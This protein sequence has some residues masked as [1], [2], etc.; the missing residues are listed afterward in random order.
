MSVVHRELNRLEVLRGL[1]VATWEAAFANI[2]VTLTTGAFLT[3]FA[4]WLGAGDVEVSLLSA[5]PTFAGLVQFVSSYFG[6]RLPARKP[7]CAWFLMAGRGLWVL[8]LLLPYLLGPSRSLYPFLVLYLL[9]YVAIN[10]PMPAYMAWMSDLVPA[11]HRGRYFGR[12]NMIAGGAGMLVGLPAAWFLDWTTR[13]THQEAL[14]FA[15]LFGVAVAG[16]VAALVCMLRQPEPPGRNTG[17]SGDR[18]QGTEGV[19]AYYR[20]PFADRNFR[21]LIMFNVVLG[22]GQFLAAPFFTVYALQSLQLNY[23][24][25]QLLSVLTSIT[26]LGS[27]PV[28]GYLADRFGNKP[29]LGISVFGTVLL[30]LY[31]VFAT[32]DNPGVMMVLLVIN[33][34]SGGASWA[35]VGLMQFNL[36]IRMSP[37]EKTAVYV[38]TM[39]AV[40][41]L[42]GGLAPL[43]GGV[44]MNALVHWRSTLLG[45]EWTNFHVTFLAA[46][47]LR[48]VA[49]GFL[50]PLVDAQAASARDVLQQLT[51]A[52]LR[53]WLHIRRL[54]GGSGLEARRR[55]TE[56]LGESRTQLAV[57]ELTTALTDPAPAVREEAARALG[58][59]GDPAA[60]EA[61]TAAL[62]D[63][64]AGIVGPAA[65]ALARIGDRRAVPAL[66][67]LLEAPEGTVSPLD[68]LAVIRALGAL[69]GT[70]AAGTLTRLLEQTQDPEI[71]EALA[72]ALGEAGEPETAQALIRFLQF[73]QPPEGVRMAI[74]HAL[75]QLGAAEAGPVLRQEL[76]ACPADSRLLPVVAEA[77]ARL[78]DRAALPLLVAHLARSSTPLS[79][80]QIALAIGMLLQASEALYTLLTQEEFARDE[81]VAR[82]IE[83]LRR[84]WR[85]GPDVPALENALAAYIREEYRECVRALEAADRQMAADKR[86]D[87]ALQTLR[88]LCAQDA[89][90]VEGALVG[91]IALRCRVDA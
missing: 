51:R 44:L 82:M 18:L 29:L 37:A 69:G 8:I 58:E 16:A 19:L 64:A 12:R 33:H 17:V 9:S 6:E 83:E 55:A 5:I 73:R 71:A 21:R 81:M 15:V 11:D 74:V 46:S 68:S 49:L 52:D 30:P 35:G 7:F 43:A 86:P 36:L 66:I 24:T 25:L 78:Q 84:R 10:I 87:E 13:K 26:G 38:A 61:L 72:R 41:G 77:L 20:A 76:Q 40:T 91:L 32:P 50:R 54:Q 4:L 60:V 70:E 31:W 67:T 75:G 89:L 90:P 85:A 48:V 53:A 57:S 63:P 45:I 56:A 65:D 62:M 23:V 39:S 88:A 27:M 2:W 80:K 22:L 1:R 14:G 79:R 3:G 42:T 47:V 59:I 34:L 28:W